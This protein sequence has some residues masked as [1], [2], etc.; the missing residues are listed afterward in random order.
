MATRPDL[1]ARLLATIDTLRQGLPS[2]SWD[3]QENGVGWLY[4]YMTGPIFIHRHILRGGVP[5]CVGLGYED[6]DASIVL[7]SADDCD[8]DACISVVL[9][10]AINT[11]AYY[12]TAIREEWR[13]KPRILS[14]SQY[15]DWIMNQNDV[16]IEAVIEALEFAG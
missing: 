2:D 11:P 12:G 9:Q 3:E 8:G 16:F 6:Q 13:A 15:V 4:N 5:I 14:V 1:R 10:A 7:T